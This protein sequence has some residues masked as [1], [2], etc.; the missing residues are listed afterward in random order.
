MKPKKFFLVEMSNPF[1][2]P[3][4]TILRPIS[5]SV[6]PI[7]RTIY[8]YFQSTSG[9]RGALLGE[10]YELSVCVCGCVFVCERD[11]EKE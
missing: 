11:G 1:L 6:S 4:C 2:S 5:T 7:E 8:N 9:G 3:I 10:G